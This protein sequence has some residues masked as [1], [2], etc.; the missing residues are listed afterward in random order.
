M[1]CRIAVLI[2]LAGA[3]TG[4]A[5]KIDPFPPDELKLPADALRPVTVVRNAEPDRGCIKVTRFSIADYYLPVLDTTERRRRW[6]ETPIDDLPWMLPPQLFAL[7]TPLPII[8]PVASE[9]RRTDKFCDTRPH[10]NTES[11]A[12]EVPS[13]LLVGAGLLLLRLPLRRRR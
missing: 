6:C 12:P 9:E 3:G 10:C 4:L 8:S 1:R 13:F 11:P 7:A 2:A 5:S